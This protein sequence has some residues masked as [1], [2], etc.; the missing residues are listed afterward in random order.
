MFCLP[1]SWK[2]MLW[3]MFDSWLCTASESLVM[4]KIGVA[5]ETVVS[6]FNP[7]FYK[8]T[9]QLVSLFLS[10]GKRLQAAKSHVI[11]SG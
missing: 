7:I 6:V 1:G 10:F 3:C 9:K 4:Q 2:F 5:H 8:L 11:V